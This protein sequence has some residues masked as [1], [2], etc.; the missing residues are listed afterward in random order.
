MHK[1]TSTLVGVGLTALLLSGCAA[2]PAPGA[3]GLATTAGSQHVESPKAT[4]SERISDEETATFDA[5]AEAQGPLG[6]AVGEVEEQ[7]PDDFAYDFFEQETLRV[8]FAGRAPEGAVALLEATGGSY[9]VTEGAGFA[10]IDY[11]AAADSVSAQV[12]RYVTEELSV[13]VA[14]DPSRE[15]GAIMVDLLSDESSPTGNPGLGSI[16]LDEPFSLFFANTSSTGDTL[17]D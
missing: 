6:I 13:S 11:Q 1:S 10:A 17:V 16:V 4:S 5:L 8:G 7:F 2:A 3:D 14:Q 12:R 15:P 9:T